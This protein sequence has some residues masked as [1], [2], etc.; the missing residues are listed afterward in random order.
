MKALFTHLAAA[1]AAIGLCYAWAGG[2][3]RWS[4]NDIVVTAQ[5]QQQLTEKFR[6]TWQRLP[7][8]Q[9]RQAMIDDYLRSEMA[10]RQALSN[11]LASRDVVVRGKMRELLEDEARQSAEELPPNR[12]Q[13]QDWLNKNSDE[14]RIGRQ[15]SFRQV[16]FDDNGKMIGADAAAR[17]MLGRLQN[18]DMPGDISEHGDASPVPND[19]IDV[20]EDDI[21]VVFGREFL[22]RMSELPTGAWNG[23]LRSSLGIHLVFVIGRSSGKV[24]ELTDV[25]DAVYDSWLK[26]ERDRAVEE[27]YGRLSSQYDVTVVSN[28]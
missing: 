3:W 22:E 15:T 10:Y 19:L 6:Q 28:P 24:P 13:L 21:A 1:V 27:L 7:E 25:E 17:F 9:E 14:F 2:H 5:V 26:A 8:E 18:Q 23:P 4:E 20:S 16:Y 12:A 11:G